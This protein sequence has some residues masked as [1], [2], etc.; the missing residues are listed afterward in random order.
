[1]RSPRMTY[2]CANNVTSTAG[3]IAS[4][5]IALMRFHCVPSSVTNCAIV[6]VISAVLW[7]VRMSANRN[8]FHV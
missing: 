1:M 4:T 5:A 8:S 6:T 2:L 3:P 7:P